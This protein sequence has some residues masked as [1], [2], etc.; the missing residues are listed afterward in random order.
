VYITV[1]M[2][3]F[4]FYELQLSLNIYSRT[5]ALWLFTPKWTRVLYKTVAA[6][7]KSEL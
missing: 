3:V 7:N 4:T 6:H 5:R 1:L 2:E